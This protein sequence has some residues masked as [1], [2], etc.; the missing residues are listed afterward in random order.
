MTRAKAPCNSSFYF[1][2]DLRPHSSEIREGERKQR[3]I[4]VGTL[5]GFVRGQV[6]QLRV[7]GESRASVID[8]EERNSIRIR[9]HTHEH[10]LETVR[11]IAVEE[12]QGIPSEPIVKLSEREIIKFNGRSEWSVRIE[13]ID[14]FES[15]HEYST[16][17]WIGCSDHVPL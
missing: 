14:V 2:K 11:H 10:G 9:L 13:Y 12:F 16:S 17:I 7:A 6:H 3:A 8:A 1:F 4:R 5:G 15:D